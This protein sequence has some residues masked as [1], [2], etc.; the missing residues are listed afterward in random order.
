MTPR[1]KKS[2]VYFYWGFW[3]LGFVNFVQYLITDA[4][5]IWVSQCPRFGSL[6]FH[7]HWV[8][9]GCSSEY[10]DYGCPRLDSVTGECGFGFF[11]AGQVRGALN[12]WC[13]SHEVGTYGC[14]ELCDAFGTEVLIYGSAL[15]IVSFVDRLINTGYFLLYSRRTAPH[16]W[17]LFTSIHVVYTMA[18]FLP[19]RFIIPSLSSTNFGV[20]LPAGLWWIV[21][22]IWCVGHR[23]DSEKGC[24]GLVWRVCLDFSK[25]IPI[26]V[27][28]WQASL[29][30]MGIRL[31]I[32]QIYS[33]VSWNSAALGIILE[34][35]SSFI[36]LV[37][38]VLLMS[39]LREGTGRTR[40]SWHAAVPT[41]ARALAPT[42]APTPAP[43]PVSA[44]I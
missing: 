1:T 44:V 4:T 42:S 38:M 43:T 19:F 3:L 28:L 21:P 20:W 18:S 13:G 23:C 27:C 35:I 32:E 33:E 31:E 5:S 34:H 14:N 41:Q 22:I 15:L 17:F 29:S 10:R 9:D 2:L 6:R 7:C 36:Y 39:E 26:G 25:I 24:D 40:V 16:W 30:P 11:S 12:D 8:N 37:M